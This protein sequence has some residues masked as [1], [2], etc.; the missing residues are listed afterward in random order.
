[1][2]VRFHWGDNPVTGW[3]VVQAYKEA[4]ECGSWYGSLPAE[5]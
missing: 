2:L 3:T 1:M 5:N 4:A